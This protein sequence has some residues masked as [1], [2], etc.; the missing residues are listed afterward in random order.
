MK[1][2]IFIVLA[3]LVMGVFISRAV[4]WESLTSM[5]STET[6][7]PLPNNG[8]PPSVEAY[9]HAYENLQKSSGTLENVYALGLRAMNEIAEILNSLSDSD[10]QIAR[11][12]MPG[13]A[14]NPNTETI[15][16]NPLPDTFLELAKTKGT[17]VDVTFFLLEKKQSPDGL[18]PS[19]FEQHTDLT[20][21]TNYNGTLT[22]LYKAWSEFQQGHPGIYT[23]RIQQ[24][25]E[26][27]LSEFTDTRCACKDADVMIKEFKSFLALKP[28]LD[29]AILE[30][31]EDRLKN[32]QSGTSD[33]QF[34]CL[35][36]G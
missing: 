11:T 33:I 24:H 6:A 19:Y 5:S 9:N 4:N 10:L 20:G 25:Q 2:Y 22:E 7:P 15:V 23:W 18:W 13:F 36:P 29:P 28:K 34:N 35:A 31:L 32:I 14:L 8:L 12:K 17:P 16:I 26:E 1:K 30:S 27:I 21:C 3:V